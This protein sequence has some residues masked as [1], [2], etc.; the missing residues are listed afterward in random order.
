MPAAFGMVRRPIT[1]AGFVAEDDPNTTAPDARDVFHPRVLV[2]EGEA[3]IANAVAMYGSFETPFASGG[4]FDATLWER[5]ARGDQRWVKVAAHAG[6]ASVAEFSDK[7]VPGADC[8]LQVTAIVGPGGATTLVLHG[9][10]AI[11]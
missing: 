5:D 1:I 11:R 10:E 3:G 8:F 4:T 6:V 7:I 2:D 9:A